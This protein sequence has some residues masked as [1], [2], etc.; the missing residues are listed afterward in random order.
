MAE[1]LASHLVEEIERFKADN[2]KNKNTTENINLSQKSLNT[3][4][5]IYSYEIFIELSVRSV[6][7]NSHD[8]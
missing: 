7:L 3:V 5:A 8:L 6:K 2:S 1:T 4:S